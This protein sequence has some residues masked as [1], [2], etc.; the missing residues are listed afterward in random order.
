MEIN[1]V[2]ISYLQDLLI[3]ETNIIDIE[4]IFLKIVI[5]KIFFKINQDMELDYSLMY[6]E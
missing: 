3:I 5:H 6:M 4:H 1:H 2:L